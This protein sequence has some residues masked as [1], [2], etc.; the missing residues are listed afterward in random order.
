MTAPKITWNGHSGTPYEFEIYPKGTTF[1]NVDGNYIFAQ[2][3]QTGWNAIYIGEGNLADRT[4]DKEHLA[5][6]SR[7]GFT[8]YHVHANSNENH[9]KYEEADLIA[10][11]TECL[12]KNGG[13]NNTSDG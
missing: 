9:R 3:T 11:H 12:L 6:A 4:Q 2:Q 5:C 10:E 7:K 8:H 1:N 13:C